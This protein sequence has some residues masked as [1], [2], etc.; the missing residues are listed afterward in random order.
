LSGFH[1]AVVSRGSAVASLSRIAP[2]K[3]DAF[4]TRDRLQTVGEAS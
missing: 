2:G 1:V 4:R 3:P